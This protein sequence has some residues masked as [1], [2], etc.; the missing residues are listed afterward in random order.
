MPTV[1]IDIC[2]YTYQQKHLQKSQLPHISY[3]PFMQ[4]GVSR[5]T[6]HYYT[7]QGDRLPVAQLVRIAGAIG[8]E[9]SELLD[10]G[11]NVIRCPH[12]GALLELKE[13]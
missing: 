1:V 5:Q 10:E 11:K 4:R 8:C 9:L 3:R 13:K 2:R 7:E 12:C 6:V